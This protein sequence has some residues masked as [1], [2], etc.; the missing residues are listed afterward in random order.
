[1]LADV[2]GDPNCINWPLWIFSPSLHFYD[3]SFASFEALLAVAG[4]AV[5][6]II[7]A[8]WERMRYRSMG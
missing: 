3:G 2:F 6:N 4:W 7:L 5:L 1:M 8:V